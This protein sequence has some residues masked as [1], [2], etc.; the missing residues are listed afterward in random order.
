MDGLKYVFGFFIKET[1]ARKSNKRLN[2]N[3]DDIRSDQCIYFRFIV[4]I[5]LI[6]ECPLYSNKP[7]PPIEQNMQIKGSIQIQ[8]G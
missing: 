8:R 5:H 4:L 7:N 1:K 2:I 6:R 3:Q